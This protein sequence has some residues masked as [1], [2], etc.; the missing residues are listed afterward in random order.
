[1]LLVQ[2]QAYRQI[3]LQLLVLDQPRLELFPNLV[4]VQNLLLVPGNQS[5]LL[6]RQI[7]P[8]VR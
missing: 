5:H 6:V 8:K 3:L 7:L 1:M 2:V 4:L